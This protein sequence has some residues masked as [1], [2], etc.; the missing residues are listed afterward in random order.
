M[1]SIIN[2]ITLPNG[3]S[4]D[5]GS[6]LLKLDISISGTTVTLN[7]YNS[8]DDITNQLMQ[9]D[10]TIIYYF[11]IRLS[12]NTHTTLFSTRAGGTYINAYFYSLPDENGKVYYIKTPNYGTQSSTTTLQSFDLANSTT[13]ITS[14]SINNSGLISYKNANNTTVFTLQLPLYNGGVE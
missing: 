2:K 10:S 3:T 6:N 7:Q 11:N 4:Y 8:W 5:I 9:A 14:A 13:S 12:D 1:P